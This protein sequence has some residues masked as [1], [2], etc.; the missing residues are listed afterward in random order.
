MPLNFSKFDPKI[1]TMKKVLYTVLLVIIGHFVLAQNSS[2]EFVR[3]SQDKNKYNV[4]VSDGTYRIVFYTPDIVETT[5]IPQE[6]SFINKSHAV[7]MDP[8]SIQTD[9]KRDRNIIHIESASVAVK[10]EKDPFQI[11]Y[12]KDEELIISEKKGY[13]K[14]SLEKIQFNLTEEE[15]LYGGGARA[16]SMKRRGHRLELYNRAHYGYEERSKLL[17]YTMPV[18]LSSKQYLVHFDNPAIGYLD[19]DSKGDNTLSYETI[20]G[21]KTYQVVAGDS[22]LDI[23]DNYTDLTGK[24]PMLPRWALGNFSSR[25]GYHSQEETMKTIRKFK[26]EEIPVDAVILDIFWFGK[27]I[28]GTMGNLAFYRD[29]FPQP[30]QMINDL[31]NKNVETILVTEP[32]I[33]TTSN[34]WEE[35]VREDILAKDSTGEPYTYDFYFGHT[36]LI[37]IFSDKGYSWLKD[38]TK[39]LLG[40]GVTGI[41]GDLGEPEVHPSDLIH[42]KGTADEVHNIYGHQWTKLVDEAFHEYNPNMRPFVLMRAG[43]SG[44]QR[45]GILPWS[46]DVNRTWGGM[47]SQPEIA[48]QMGMQ[49]VGYMHSDLGGFAGDNLDDELYVRWLQYGVFQPI[50]RPHA[51]EEVPSE[52]VYRSDK[53]KRLAKKAIE[54]RYRL[55]PYNYHLVYKNHKT[56]APLMR[57]LLFEEP[58]NE[59]LYHYDDAYLWGN[60]ILVAPIVEAGKSKKS[61]YFPETSNWFDFY[62]DKKYEGGKTE[63]VQVNEQSIPTFV[64]GGAFIPMTKASQTTKPYKG[65]ELILHHFFDPEL[66][67]SQSQLYN[68]D[69]STVKPVEKGKYELMEFCAQQE[70]NTLNISFEGHSGSN[71]SPSAKS[72]EL[73]IHNVQTKP[74]KVEV[75]GKTLPVNWDDRSKYLKINLNWNVQQDIKVEVEFDE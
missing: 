73:I 51:Q 39:R 43:Y 30:R 44:S 46:G 69:G 56:G 17:N 68:D 60:D 57:P 18:V 24:Q 58:G 66:E 26:Q 38:Q 54:L 45:Y 72:I 22:W 42:A 14:D 4:K 62:T 64:R 27:T 59:E 12:Y 16:L 21:R 53:A 9:V 5:F 32:F 47:K 2:R 65:H 40:M 20:S 41:W 33:L 8:K 37:D 61:V 15:A 10:I 71:Y 11:S 13:L 67:K 25:F 28:K 29:S 52:P 35:A 49:G 3:F 31:Q 7:V 75:E 50:Y 74:E 34:R 36:G 19:L 55:L 23:I 70:D 6:E 48:L 63:T 1:K